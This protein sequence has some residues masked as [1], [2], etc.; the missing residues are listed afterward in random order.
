MNGNL[1]I[2]PKCHERL[3][4][5]GN[6]LVCGSGHCFDVSK[7][8][9]VNLLLANQKHTKDPGDD[10]VMILARDEFL[11]RGYF[12][13]LRNKL[14]QKVQENKGGVVLDAGCGTG[15][16][17][18]P[19]CNSDVVAVDISKEAARMTAKNN[20]NATTVV[21]SIFNLPIMDGAVDII[22]NVFAPK[23]QDEFMRVLNA[24]GKIIEVVPARQHMKE[25]KD[26]LFEDKA[27]DNIEKFAFTNFN[28]IGSEKLTY[29]VHLS[30]QS[31]ILNLVKMTPYWHT[32]GEKYANKLGDVKNLSTTFDFVINTWEKQ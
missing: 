23:P 25:I 22:L 20:K 21:A 17:S 6:S 26:L 12:D 31:D 32:G 11:K 27:K 18:S 10:K 15:Y 30:D 16:Y 7:F 2:C 3:L 29:A 24:G 1:L 14:C 8:G 13:K 5:S 9:Y 28:L 19:L 4:K